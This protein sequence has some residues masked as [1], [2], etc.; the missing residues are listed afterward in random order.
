MDQLVNGLPLVAVVLALVEWV[1]TFG[2]A[3]KAL[4]G[5][6]M[7]IGLAVGV[8]Y[9]VSVAVPVGFAGWFGAAI[10]GVTLGLVASGLYDAG[11]SIAA[12]V[13]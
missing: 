7:L 2:L 12:N 5:V 11:K 6:S 3:G 4:R 1:K 8:A 9:Q 10:Y 13:G